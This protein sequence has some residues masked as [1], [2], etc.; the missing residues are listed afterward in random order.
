MT[1]GVTERNK[2]R[3]RRELAEAAAKLFIERGYAATTVQ[4]IVEAADVSPRTFFRYFP[5]KEDVI[6]AIASMSLDDTIDHLAGHDAMEELGAVLRAMLEDA[7][8]PVGED[9]EAARAFQRMLRDTPALR[10]RW[11]EEQRLSRDRLAAALAPW[12]R[13]DSRPL[14]PHLA[15]GMA[16]LAIDEVMTSWAD[17]PSTPDPL[18]LLDQAL[19]ILASPLFKVGAPS[20]GVQPVSS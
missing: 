17:D 10:G 14:A 4:D 8:A 7:L 11:L 12:F 1:G 18:R 15:A 9:P 6:T 3:T 19:D 16:Q 5:S 20:T 13:D 2:Q